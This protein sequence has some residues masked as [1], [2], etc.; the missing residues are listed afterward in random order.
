[1]SFKKLFLCVLI[2]TIC[3]S[4][5]SQPESSSD[6][7]TNMPPKNLAEAIFVLDAQLDAETKQKMKESSRDDMVRYHLGL[8]MGLRNEWK[9]W[10]D[11]KLAQQFKANGIYSADNM[12]GLIL[13]IYWK[14]LNGIPLSL[15]ESVAH[16]R[17]KYDELAKRITVEE[18]VIKEGDEVMPLPDP[19]NV[20]EDLVKLK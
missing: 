13:D 19:A 12:S 7:K 3:L 8:G 14:H 17:Q 15:K 20:K 6:D 4:C 10:H 18:G 9:L 16:L 5:Y 2:S 1:M 11:S